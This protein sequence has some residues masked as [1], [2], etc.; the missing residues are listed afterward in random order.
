MAGRG[1]L[2]ADRHG[3]PMKRPTPEALS[4]L[5]ERLGH[6]FR[7]PALLEEALTH[8]SAVA[9]ARGRGRTYQ[10]LE[11]LGDRVLALAVAD[12]LMAAYPAEPEGALSRRHTQLV[13]AETCAEVARALGLGGFVVL[14]E[15]EAQSGGRDKGAI[16]SD[17]AEAVIGAI[18][19]DGGYEPARRFV[20]TA[21]GAHVTDPPSADLRDAKTRLQEWA[22]ARGY[23][24]PV[25][26]TRER[27]GPD[28]APEFVMEVVV[29]GL[30]RAEGAG[31]SKRVA[32]QAAAATLLEAQP[33]RRKAKAKP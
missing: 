24:T 25:Y 7:E 17:V 32:E 14:G 5:A 27:R 26:A 11:F 30:G 16:L 23:P 22:Q 8:P 2:G 1:A 4:A 10:R 33:A 3:H 13:R 31:P 9:S 15:G 21:W 28:H 12:M 29:D 6:V 19:L 20:T 18:Y